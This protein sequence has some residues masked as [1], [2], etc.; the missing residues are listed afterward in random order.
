MNSPLKNRFQIQIKSLMGFQ[1]E[2]FV[3]ELFLLKYG[4]IDFIPTRPVRDKGCD[5]LI[6]SEGIV[7]ACYAPEQY[8]KNE[9]VKKADSDFEQYEKHWENNYPKWRVIVNHELSPDQTQK[10]ISLKGTS[11]LLGLSQ[12]INIVEDLNAYQRRKLAQYLNIENEFFSQ[13]YISEVLEDLFKDTQTS[14]QSVP[15]SK[16]TYIE[17][18]VKLNYGQEDID[19]ALAEY[20]TLYEYFILIRDLIQAYDDGEKD[21]I[22]LRIINDYQSKN[23]SFKDKLNQITELY[24]AKYSHENDD[25]Y[26]FY[27]R[28]ILLYHFE[29]CLIGIKT[30]EGK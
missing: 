3:K 27:I 18:K 15:Y 5:G 8:D 17:E 25:D 1:F 4:A 26:L 22:K 7:I 6:K 2:E 19:S 10:V 29:Q 13:D 23:G 16:P 21:R 14:D 11:E 12:I 24:L 30:S 9:F 20:E 28:A